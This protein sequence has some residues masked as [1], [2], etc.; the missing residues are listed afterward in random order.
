M[1]FIIEK[2][3]TKGE[4]KVTAESRFKKRSI[5]KVEREQQKPFMEPIDFHRS[6]SSESP[7]LFSSYTMA[8][9]DQSSR[10]PECSPQ[11]HKAKYLSLE[12]NQRM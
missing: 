9:E 10:I 2:R 12:S 7:V 1:K 11:T 6:H 3:Q 4:K 8:Q 5:E